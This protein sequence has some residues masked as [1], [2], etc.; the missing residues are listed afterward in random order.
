MDIIIVILLTVLVVVL[1]I[2][3]KIQFTC[4]VEHKYIQPEPILCPED[5][6]NAKEIEEMNNK[7]IDLVKEI[8]DIMGVNNGSETDA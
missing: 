6:A 7:A 4:T 1:C 2:K 5:E 3:G 8:N